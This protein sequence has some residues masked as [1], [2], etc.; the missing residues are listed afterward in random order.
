MPNS[1]H[2]M[3]QLIDLRMPLSLTEQDCDL[4][5]QI[6]AVAADIASQH[7]PSSQERTPAP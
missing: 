3:W 4:I 2:V 5:G 6:I 1:M 7:Q